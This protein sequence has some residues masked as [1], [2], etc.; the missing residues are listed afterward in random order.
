MDGDDEGNAGA[1]KILGG[2]EDN[3][4]MAIISAATSGWDRAS[5]REELTLKQLECRVRWFAF[6]WR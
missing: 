3:G 2:I 1:G 5:V 6:D 4:Q